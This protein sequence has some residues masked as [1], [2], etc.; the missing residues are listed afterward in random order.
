MVVPG[1]A[2]TCSAEPAGEGKL[3]VKAVNQHGAAVLTKAVAE[4]G[5]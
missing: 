5:A 2:V 3:E 4:Y 1:D